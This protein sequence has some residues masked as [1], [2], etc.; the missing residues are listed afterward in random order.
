MI[1][2][3]LC[4]IVK[5]EEKTLAECLNSV[6]D[7]ADEIIIVDTGSTDKTK[8]IAHSFTDKVYD[9]EWINDFAAARNFAF[10]KATKEYQLW[11][12][13]D[14]IIIEKDKIAFLNL[15][16]ELSPAIDM[17]LMKYNYV[18]DENN[19]PSYSFQ[20]ERLVKRVN[21]YK[22]NDPVHEYILYGDNYLISEIAITHK[23]VDS[24]SDR[25]LKIYEA[26]LKNN[27]PFSPRSLYYYARELR[28]HH[29]YEEAIEY[30]N[31]FLDTKDGAVD[32]NINACYEIGKIY[33]QLNDTD[34]ALR[35]FFQ[36][37]SYDIPRAESCCEIALIYMANKDYRKAIYW[38]EFV[39]T[40]KLSDTDINKTSI[41][42]W[43]FVPAIQLA[44]C[45]ANIN[46]IEKAIAYNELAGKYKIDHDSVVHN[47]NYFNKLG[48]NKDFLFTDYKG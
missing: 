16:K 40:L 30:F 26:Q 46:N 5:N 19:N 23:K 12:D 10:S 32:D 4:M 21:N 15:K 27:L 33:K 41:D 28:D 43:S 48:K 9:F 39:F 1:T 37:F 45:Y 31:K 11:L 44:V 8:E 25:N 18:V 24:F 17:V 35:Y 22:W 13:A 2:I 42:C 47:R 6:K 3:S 29:K 7:I 20:R 34:N 14:D 36:S 38:Y